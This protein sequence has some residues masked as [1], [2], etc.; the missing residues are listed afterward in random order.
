MYNE[1]KMDV[2]AGKPLS[3]NI[4]GNFNDYPSDT[5]CINRSTAQ[6]LR[7]GE[8]PLNGKGLPLTLFYKN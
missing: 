2:H 8:N 4:W 5:N 7:V 3:S 1:F 6:S